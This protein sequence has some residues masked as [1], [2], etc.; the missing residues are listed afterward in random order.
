MAKAR[1][2]KVRKP[3]KRSAKKRKA[4]AKSKA[5]RRSA[6]AKTKRKAKRAPA[7][8]ISFVEAV[9]GGIH[10]AAELRRRLAGHDTFE[11]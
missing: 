7:R 1:K 8:K 2:K 4:A 5:R 10:E 11:D 9:A 6:K 3:A